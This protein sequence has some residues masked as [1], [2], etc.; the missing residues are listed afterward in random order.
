[1]NMSEQAYIEGDCKY[2]PCEGCPLASLP[3]EQLE[4]CRRG[5][6]TLERRHPYE[7][8][9]DLELVVGTHGFTM[10]VRNAVGGKTRAVESQAVTHAFVHRAQG[11]CRFDTE[12]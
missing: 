4:I 9:D 1:M 7:E 10:E 3:D 6:K 11:N 12:I 5:L 8:I 2:D